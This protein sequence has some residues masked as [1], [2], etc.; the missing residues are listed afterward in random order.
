MLN[1]PGTGRKTFSNNVLDLITY[2]NQLDWR[3]HLDTR[4]IICPL[5]TLLLLLSLGFNVN[6]DVIDPYTAA[7]GPF[8][9]GPGE[10]IAEE[11]LVVLTSSVL[12]GFRAALPAVGDEAAAGSEA[13][14]EIGSGVFKCSMD[15]PNVDDVNNNAACVSGYDRGEGPVFDLSGSTR[16]QFDVQS[17][18][19]GMTLGITLIDTNEV[20]SLGFVENVTPGQLV[21]PFDQ[22]ISTTGFGPGADLASIDNIAMVILNQPGKEGS[23]ILGEFSTDGPI[24]AGP[25]VP[26]DDEIVAQELSGSYFDPTRDGEGCQL[27]LERDGATFILTCYFY[28]QGEQFWLIGI[29][30]L[31]NGQI[32]FSDMIIT[33]GAEYGAGFDPAD[34][35]RDVWGSMTMTWADCNN[36]EL[37]LI[38]VL[39]GYEQLT[40]ELIR[41]VPTTCGGGGVQGDALP[42]MGAFFDPARDGEGFHLGVE[43]DGS[44]FVMTW[45]TYL[46]GEQVWMIGTG[47]RDGDQLVFQDMII[48]RGANFGSEFD[49]ADV[50]RESFGSITA[51]FSDCN[52]FTATV[53]SALPE[54]SDIVLNV[55]KIVAGSCP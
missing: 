9:V 51:D 6:A 28:D 53:D 46:E 18:N 49:P 33:S 40:L 5:F 12:G 29:G 16:F 25:S 38:P 19:G 34:V 22:L 35:V 23:V 17:V 11:D 3:A 8:T 15:F 21:I 26:T 20:L 37:E 31:V 39:A 24:K 54:F 43:G 14:L 7:Q 30:M 2:L 4:I 32:I 47:I 52:N 55:T 42:W 10:E 45:Y 13:T 36:A 41:L 44:T 50:I 1:T 48:T 27:T